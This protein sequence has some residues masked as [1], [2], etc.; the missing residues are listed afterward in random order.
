MRG[1]HRILPRVASHKIIARFSTLKNLV[2]MKLIWKIELHIPKI[3]KKEEKYEPK[4][5]IFPKGYVGDLYSGDCER[6]SPE[7]LDKW[8]NQKTFISGNKVIYQG[9]QSLY[10]NFF[11][12]WS[13][14]L[15]VWPKFS[16]KNRFKKWVLCSR[17][18]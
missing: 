14:L 9:S 15:R 16:L 13:P 18:T 7:S 5:N 12:Q 11:L 3:H 2:F 8:I 4:K 17:P 10:P 6:E 1:I